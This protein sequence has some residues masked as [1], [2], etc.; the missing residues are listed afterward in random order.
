MQIK[1]TFKYRLYPS[2]KQQTTIDTQLEL[3][4]NLYN[5]LLNVKKETYEQSKKSLTKFDLNKC[6]FYFNNRNPEFKLIHSQVKQNISDRIDKA[7]KNMFARIKRGEEKV[8]FPR[9]KGRGRYKSICYPQ[10]G[11]QLLPNHKLKV[12]KIGDMN[13]KLHRPIKG[14]IKTLTINKTPTNKIG[15]S[16]IILTRKLHHIGFGGYPKKHNL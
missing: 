3:C 4:R 9:F 1:R 12:S 10:S 14:D 2:K 5:E 13:I 6:M 16:C 8:G 7:F 11:Y 15:C